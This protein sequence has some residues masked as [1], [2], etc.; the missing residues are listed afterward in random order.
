M[1]ELSP[2]LRLRRRHVLGV[3]QT[4]R[5]LLYSPSARDWLVS[6]TSFFLQNAAYNISSEQ[7]FCCLHGCIHKRTSPKVSLDPAYLID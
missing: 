6:T 3:H 5:W 7:S 4:S 2:N 1:Y